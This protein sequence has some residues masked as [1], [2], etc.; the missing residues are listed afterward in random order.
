MRTDSSSAATRRDGIL[1]IA[2]LTAARI[3]LASTTTAQPAPFT[4]KADRLAADATVYR[5]KHGVPHIFAKNE[6]ALY[7]AFGYAQAEDHL[8]P[9]LRSYLTATGNMAGAFGEQF[10]SSDY[11]ARLFR[12]RDMAT[13]DYAKLD[14]RVQ[15]M[16]ESF[17]TGANYYIAT[18]RADMPEWAGRV[19]PA[20]II[21]LMKYFIHI[22]Y[23]IDFQ[24]VG[25]QIAPGS[26][27]CVVGTGRSE[28]GKTMLMGDLHLP[29]SGLTQLYE[30]HLHCPGLN[31]SGATL[32]GL[33]VIL[34]GH[35]E[36][37]AW[38]ITGNRPEVADVFAER[39]S[40]DHPGH[41]LDG[42]SWVPMDRIEGEIAVAGPSGPRQE[43]RV[44]FYTRRGP[45]V[46]IVGDTAYAVRLSGW[47][48]VNVLLGWYLINR[49]TGLDEFKAALA[50]R[51]IPVFNFLYTDVTGNIYYVYNGNVPVKSEH[52]A[53]DAPVPGWTHETQWTGFL[54]FDQLP[55]TEN[56][57]SGFLLNCNNPPWLSTRNCD[58]YPARFPEYI[59][60]D[61][62][63]FRGRRMMELLADDTSVTV[64][65]LKELPWD[66]YV[67]MAEMAKPLISSAVD[68]LE[69]AAPARATGVKRAAEIIAQWNNMC[70]VDNTGAV[71]FHVWLSAY[72]R[73]FP[74]VPIP[75]L[76]SRMVMPTLRETDA[77]IRA[78]EEAIALMWKEYGRLDVRW[79]NIRKMRRGSLE[80]DIGG[81]GLID[82][83]NQIVEGQFVEGVSYAGGG[84]AFVMV[85]HM[86][87]PVETFTIVPFGSSENPGS[88]HYADQ[89]ALFAKCR[90]KKALFTRQDIFSNLESAWGSDISLEFPGEASSARVSAV[91]PMIVTAMVTPDTSGLP[92]PEGLKALT[93]YFYLNGPPA[94]KPTI[95][96]TL[97]IQQDKH[98]GAISATE[99][100][101]L[102]YLSP[103]A[104]KWERCKSGFDPAK[105]SVRGVGTQF[106]TYAVF[107]K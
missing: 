35:N 41:Y 37:I 4:T 84:H 13:A 60:N 46:N 18:H 95:D 53:R 57:P 83:L 106:G 11:H 59:S 94:S 92:P 72:R 28:S 26:N 3:A 69:M 49:A 1:F 81:A 23:Q 20:D 73:F 105:N 66:N 62:V 99:P 21:A 70:D 61:P 48:D 44:F 98:P 107:G 86:T 76:V 102:F 63:T 87:D 55:Q 91:K 79:G 97:K 34:I 71:L 29:W 32:F 8:E 68:R 5:D 39:L 33:P 36:R 104:A 38:T 58:I 56:P 67:L 2:L 43:K 54:S 6:E 88:A 19:A 77:A 85:A 40:R 7:F 103:R 65:E 42:I 25:N 100:P 52:L 30:A 75:D 51:H 9:M 96:L 16:V 82:P 93:N 12:F 17:A 89:M 14:P 47:R 10:L 31:V 27:G 64:D 74:A 24:N 101:A 50:L 22:Y 15:L 45:V 78:L 90:L 80:H